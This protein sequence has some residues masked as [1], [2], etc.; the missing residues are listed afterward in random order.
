M[1]GKKTQVSLLERTE[2]TRNAAGEPEESWDV[3]AGGEYIFVHIQ[4]M[5]LAKLAAMNQSDAGQVF[6]NSLTINF[7]A[8]FDIDVDDRIVDKDGNQYVIQHVIP[9]RS[10][11]ETIAGITNLQ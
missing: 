1:R 7:R 10:H 8:G 9:Y 4:R 6:T 5:T 3:P 11:V 2:G